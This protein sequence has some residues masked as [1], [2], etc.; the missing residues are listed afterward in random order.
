MTCRHSP[1]DPSCS[2][3]RGYVSPYDETSN[4]PDSEKYAIEDVEQ[5]GAH[6]VLKIRYPNCSKCS[7]EGVKVLVYLNT[8]TRAALKWRKIDPH[9]ADPKTRRGP[10]E[11]PSPAARFPASAEG[12]ADAMA[13][14][15][16]KS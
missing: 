11:A 16:S 12:W 15:K 2:S 10:T 3:S 14:A 5:I 6:L 4:K 1:G 8:D 9:F 7:Y 13:Y